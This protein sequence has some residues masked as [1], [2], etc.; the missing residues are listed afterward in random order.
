MS[1]Y[2]FMMFNVFFTLSIFNPSAELHIYWRVL[3]MSVISGLV[4][5]E[6]TRSSRLL[7]T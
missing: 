7:V 2:S 4:A 3:T 1:L 6:E 5:S